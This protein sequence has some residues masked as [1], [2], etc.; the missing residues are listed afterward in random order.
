MLLLAQSEAAVLVSW[1]AVMVTA[2]P[3]WLVI[4]SKFI[5]IRVA[6]PSG[7]QEPQQRA[8][9]KKLFWG[10]ISSPTTVASLSG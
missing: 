9:F 7:P 2:S 8:A 10:E 6:A 4:T 3:S 5:W 1:Q